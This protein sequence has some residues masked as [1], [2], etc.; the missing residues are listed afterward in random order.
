LKRSLATDTFIGNCMA[1]NYGADLV[2]RAKEVTIQS[3]QATTPGTCIE[4]TVTT[5]SLNA[6]VQFNTK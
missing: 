4:N 3:L 6:V 2:C 5:I 1:E